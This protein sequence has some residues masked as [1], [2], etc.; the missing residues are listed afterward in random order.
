MAEE[1]AVRRF[2][3]YALIAIVLMILIYFASMWSLFTILETRFDVAQMEM[4]SLNDATS[5]EIRALH[6]SVLANRALIRDAL[7]PDSFPA[8]EAV[9]SGDE[10]EE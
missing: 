7:K 9:P 4:R 3:L 5:S 6:R 8:M 2:D 10:A 1:K